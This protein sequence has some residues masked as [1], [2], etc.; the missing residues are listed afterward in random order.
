M[1]KK[2]MTPATRN[3]LRLAALYE[4]AIG[5]DANVKSLSGFAAFYLKSLPEEDHQILL[6][7]QKI[8]KAELRKLMNLMEIDWGKTATHAKP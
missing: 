2:P 1:A 6:T 7:W 5:M 4:T 3:E 8:K